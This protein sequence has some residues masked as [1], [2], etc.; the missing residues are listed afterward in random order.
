MYPCIWVLSSTPGPMPSLAL[1][2]VSLSPSPLTGKTLDA[3]A[4]VTLVPGRASEPRG[5]AT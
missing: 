5:A 4:E 1:E 3:Q 2:Q